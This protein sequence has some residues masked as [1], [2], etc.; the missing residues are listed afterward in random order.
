MIW[1]RLSGQ[2]GDFEDSTDST[3]F[4][5]YDALVLSGGLGSI[6]GP[7]MWGVSVFYTRASLT[8]PRA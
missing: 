8:G 4:V 3:G 7:L 6:R 1:A 5:G 2:R